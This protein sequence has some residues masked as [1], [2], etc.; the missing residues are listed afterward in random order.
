[1][2]DSAVTITGAETDTELG[3]KIQ[4]ALETLTGIGVGNVTVTGSKIAGYTIEFNNALAGTDITGLT[5]STT[6]ATA[7][8]TISTTTE[9]KT[10]VNETKQISINIPAQTPPP[11]TISAAETVKGLPG[12]SEI[13]YILFTDP[14]NGYGSYDI[15]LSAEPGVNVTGV[16][17]KQSM[18]LTNETNIT[19]ALIN[20]FSQKYPALTITAADISVKFNTASVG[21]H[22][23]D[24]TFKSD[25]AGT[26]IPDITITNHLSSGRILPRNTAQGISGANETQTITITNPTSATGSYT[27]SLKIGATTYS[28][29]ALALSA[30]ASNIQTALN[31]ALGAA[32][33]ATVSGANGAYQITFSGALAG[34]DLNL[35]LISKTIDT[36]APSGSFTISTAG[37]TAQ[38]VTYTSN[39][40]TQAANIKTAI[41]ALYSAQ[42][43]DV[44]VTYDATSSTTTL[45][46]Y[47]I[48]FSGALAGT[49]IAD[50]ST[51][52]SL[53][54][55]ASVKPYNTTQGLAPIGE[56]QQAVITTTATDATFT[57]TFGA[58]TTTALNLNA[59]Q[60]E[61]QTALTAIAAP[62]A[63]IT[64]DSF[65]GKEL[66]LSFG[67]ALAG[68]N[69]ADISMTVTPVAASVEL[70]TKQTGSTTTIPAV[71]A[72]TIVIDYTDANVN[73]LAGTAGKTITL[74]LDGSKGEMIRAY[75]HLN[76]SLFGFVTVEGG[77]GFEKSTKIVT[78]NDV[79]HS[80]V[81]V[82]ALLL[83]MAGVNAFA[84]SPG[85]LADP[86]DDVGLKFTNVDFG[87]SILTETG[88]AKRKWTAVDS[89]IGG[90]S[91]VGI[92]SDVT[93][94]VD[95][96]SI[97]MNKKAADNTVVDFK[98]MET[99][100][101]ALSFIAGV[102]GAGETKTVTFGI[103][104]KKGD[105]L[106]VYGH[107]AISLA[108]F[109][110]VEGG[111]GFEKSSRQVTLSD[112]TTVDTNVLVF[113]MADVNAFAGY[114][115]ATSADDI[116]LRFTNVDFALVT[117][118]EIAGSKR[119]WT[120]IDSTIG[121][122]EFVG[123]PD[124][125]LAVDNT[126]IIMNKKA[127]ATDATV[128]D[129]KAMQ[130]DDNAFTAT[131]GVN[132]SGE[133]QTVT[134]SIDGK[135]GDLLKVYGHT[136]INLFDFV[137]V[138]GG[139]G[140]EKSTRTVT[141]S[142]GA[143][144][145]TSMTMFGMADVNAFAGVKGDAIDGSDD[146]GIKFTHIDFALATFKETTGSRKWTAVDST[147]GYAG[148]VGIPGVTLAVDDTH[149][150][151]NKKASDNTVIDFK[152]MQTAGNAYIATTGVNA[153]GVTKT[154]TFAI[155]GK[156]GDLLQ[157]YGHATINLFDFVSV[158]GG[159]G[160]EKSTRTVTLSSGATV[161][162]SMTMFGM[163]DVNAFA[164]YSGDVVDPTDDIGLK[165]T[166]VDF[167]L[168]TF[169]E[170]TGSRKWTAVDST[171]GGAAFEG[172]P[173]VT[174]AVDNTHIVMN[175]KASDNTVIDFK[176]MQTAGNAYIAT[177][178]VNIAGVVQTVTF[179]IDGRKG[180]LL[181]VYGHTDIDLFGLVTVRGGFAF[182][183]SSRSI[184]LSN[185]TTAN[186]SVM[187]FGMTDVDAFLGYAGDA[188]DGSEDFGL[189]FKN[190]DLA[191][192][193]FSEL[194]GR[195]WT[196]VES[197]IGSAEVL[198]L[199]G[200][201]LGVNQA[202]ILVSK[203]ASDGTVVDFGKMKTAGNA[204]DI[205]TG[206]DDLGVTRHV[207]FDLAGSRGEL[208]KVEADVTIHLGDFV[209]LDGII[210]FEKS[211]S[212]VYVTKGSTSTKKNLNVISLYGANL[213]A[214]VGV[215]G[216]ATDESGL[217][218]TDVDFSLALMNDKA[219]VQ[220]WSALK[221]HAGSVGIVGFGDSLTIS[222]NEVNI[223]MNRA[224]TDGSV[225]D[226][227]KTKTV[228]GTTF[229]STSGVIL[230]MKG[231]DG[232]FLKASAI[233]DLKVGGFFDVS[234]L[235]TLEM[236]TR[237]VALSSGGIVNADM[238]AFGAGG[239]DAFVGVNGVGL[240][241]K[242]VDFQLA[243]FKE[244]GGTRSWTALKGSGDQL[245]VVGLPGITIEGN[246][247]DVAIN[248]AASDNSSI[249]FVKTKT[250]LNV[251]IGRSDTAILDMKGITGGSIAASGQVKLRAFDFFYA[252]ATLLFERG[253]E[254]VTLNTGA[255]V[256]VDTLSIGALDVTAFVGVNGGS[257]D[258][259]GFKIDNVD[260][261]MLTMVE[262]DVAPASARTWSA[263]KATADSVGF[264]GMDFMELSG[265]AISVAINRIAK[266]NSIVDFTTAPLTIQAG[267]TSASITFDLKK[268][269]KSYAAISGTF[270][271]GIS[272][273]FSFSKSL[274]IEQT[275]ETVTVLDGNGGNAQQVMVGMFT[276][277]KGE[278]NAFA[279]INGGTDDEFGFKIDN[280]NVGLAIVYSTD[281]VHAG[282]Y[283]IAAK[284]NADTIGFV[285][286]D[287]FNITAS[288]L[289]VAI[290]TASNDGSSIDFS[291]YLQGDNTTIGFP[292]K[293]GIGG[294]IDN[295]SAATV[296]TLD[297]K[298]Q[299]LRAS[300]HLD[301]NLFSFVKLNGNFSFEKSTREIT[302][303]DNTK[304][305]VD[306]LAL[307]GAHV[308]AFAGVDDFGFN[309]TD[310]N[311]A[312]LAMTDKGD[313]KR[314]WTAMSAKAGSVSFTG[315][316]DIEI[317]APNISLNINFASYDDL[318]VNFGK[319][320]TFT[321]PGLTMPEMVSLG[322]D[323]P[324]LGN[325]GL[326]S[327]INL[328][329]MFH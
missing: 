111:F 98:T 236:A 292:V 283:W 39:T 328:S 138:E 274:S 42:P 65:T 275:F 144:V 202:K 18:T 62:G 153:S 190:V 37:Q 166:N 92:S 204:V 131:T 285:G 199:P 280:A 93:L 68:I 300:G 303:S 55:Y 257:A 115:G 119:K 183:R 106:Q 97:I 5:L 63:T 224:A 279:G 103:D 20:L 56:S 136:T 163:T 232:D 214:F 259:M 290:N 234:G 46:N 15:S 222:A 12:V 269:V 218:M 148:F 59:T 271:F 301:L 263:M 116:G 188:T 66:R 170:T 77:F 172:I 134:F 160:F 181:Q 215:N 241:I 268:T 185:N 314:Q 51:N 67:G 156:K 305:T 7:T 10:G 192:V 53:L 295:S 179:G 25:L 186:T 167:A 114:K 239:L 174:L 137:S 117:F 54:S 157:V 324:K 8:T 88:G 70:T 210:G 319:M 175:K 125:T 96:T 158:E 191:L 226:F 28:T 75:G 83:G 105:L 196:A 267:G 78:L 161:N 44:T 145:S 143:T 327:F 315:L 108:G 69:V 229:G 296:V 197:N 130:T 86:T 61:V 286:P 317:S 168:A 244:K 26:D 258:E 318:N 40:A 123:I 223:D 9:A 169:K 272:G 122:A 89:T 281:I 23:Y 212:D 264:V 120:A 221:A 60:A 52:S 164:G 187:A 228:L 211:T 82:D 310:L 142:S 304:T 58:S 121:A 233:F 238:F 104:G 173:D 225:I 262:S 329:G 326:G 248:M 219:G 194:G 99:A 32:G 43:S 180:D 245:A 242:N 184:T 102:N 11:V 57:I 34:Q 151:M 256:G 165:F 206:V 273:F 49:D 50:I 22:Q 159:F 288:H 81:T 147:I 135:N 320:P 243:L 36:T 30:T 306:M 325:L 126:H 266:D 231:A 71:A 235:F 302:L 247:L 73:V 24:I 95:N 252:D 118:T 246:N 249:D 284:A 322:I 17:F 19:N 110:T 3:A 294:V 201:T 237:R 109:V 6:A 150:I 299:M 311:F 227:V 162:T 287:I 213:N 139:F 323:F 13:K 308:N 45:K 47:T 101:T 154:V 177:T 207:I 124:I 216:G 265:S 220:S 91:F 90:A 298:G 193:T 133:V 240:S 260:F 112:A 76:L 100:G 74:D 146:I 38:T 16:I 289:D 141:L 217:K 208:L 14:Y 140:F 250:D 64:V 198:G 200:I 113:G 29:T 277:G 87:L 209:M 1:S 152:A 230:D 255:T 94:E 33:T 307:T 178:G 270:T 155:D 41:T 79:S 107:T 127:S 80:Q 276:F 182:E 253:H 128:I 149:I 48:T 278:I 176:A 21:G 189:R 4:T 129:F 254:T 84:G 282:Q 261:A 132:A 203:A 27:L 297:M 316:S 72:G 321:L 171:I 309:I 85:V 313:T 312:F 195:H 35:L 293:E 31:T 2:A 205:I 291:Q 251:T